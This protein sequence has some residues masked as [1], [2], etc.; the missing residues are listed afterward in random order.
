MNDLYL[1]CKEGTQSLI[2]A[3]TGDPVGSKK[4]VH[5]L[6]TV[7]IPLLKSPLVSHLAYDVFCSFRNAAFEPTEDYLRKSY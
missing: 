3:I 5:L 7:V 2:A 6:I 1:K 4:Y